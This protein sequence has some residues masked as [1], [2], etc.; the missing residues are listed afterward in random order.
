[1]TRSVS[2]LSI[3]SAIAL[4]AGLAAAADL[5]RIGTLG[6][7]GSVALDIND[8]G[9]V[10]GQANT[11]GDAAAHAYIWQAGLIHELSSL[12]AGTNSSAEAINN[13]GEVVGWSETAG[14]LKN[15][16][17]W[18]NDQTVN[19]NTLLGG[20]ASLAWDINDNGVMVG[21]GNILPG[22]AKG[23]I[24]SMN[25]GG[26]PAG[27]LPGYQGGANRAINNSNVVVGH[28]FFFGDPD[29]A[30]RA[31]QNGK[32]GWDSVQVGPVGYGL[33][34][35]TDVNS[36]GTMVGYADVT[37]GPWS[38]V[39]FTGDSKN[40]VINLGNLAGF[41]ETEAHAIN[42]SGI[43]VGLA[44]P[45]DPFDYAHAWV[46]MNGQMLDLNNLV[47]LGSQWQV[48]TAAYGINAH[49]DIVG[50]GI[51][52]D[53]SVAGFVLTGIVP[54]PGSLGLALTGGLLAL[55]RRR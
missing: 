22:F 17:Y 36:A 25:A 24:Y 10:V 48:L 52:A 12:N 41:A 43:I 16:M 49:G 38:A 32:G 37:D 2:V 55:R 20:A 42:D 30:H 14:G 33:S 40:P 23:W 35:A 29:H 4:T 3:V 47:D 54:A 45:V 18:H 9:Q 8:A 11:P 39:I 1:M 13:H 27:T 50:T 21:Q 15:A 44:Y 46:Y 6:G 51:T 34:I 53:G 31:V 26:G 19:V 28:S 5:T 7:S